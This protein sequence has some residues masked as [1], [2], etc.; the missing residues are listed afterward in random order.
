MFSLVI[1]GSFIAWP[2]LLAFSFLVEGPDKIA[3]CLMNLEWPSIGAI[4][5]I[6]CVATWFGFGSWN[7]LVQRYPLSTIAP[8][9]LLVPIIGTISSVV[10]L[11]EPLQIWKIFAAIL[12]V[13][14]LCISLLGPRLAV[15]KKQYQT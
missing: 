7:W 3:N 6:V 10:C 13:G 14:G 8:F 5:Y 2:P 4:S 12:V 11:G 1:W 9:T 15:R